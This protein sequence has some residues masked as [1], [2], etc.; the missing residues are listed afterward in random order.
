MLYTLNKGNK[1]IDG[2][3]Q[4]HCG[5]WEFLNM[6]GYNSDLFKK[7]LKSIEQI[8]MSEQRGIS[9]AIYINWFM[10]YWSLNAMARVH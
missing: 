7:E 5:T 4:V 10:Q 8:D 3:P 9:A 2:K 6:N 1:K